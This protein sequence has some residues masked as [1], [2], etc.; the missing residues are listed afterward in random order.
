MTATPGTYYADGLSIIADYM[1]DDGNRH[2][3]HVADVTNRNASN[4]PPSTEEL[5]TARLLA[6]APELLAMLETATKALIGD[7]D[8]WYENITTPDGDIPDPYDAHV[9][10]QYD[11]E[12]EAFLAI[13][14]KSKG[15]TA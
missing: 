9:L 2:H 5:D 12:I 6:A 3:V 1:D 8:S 11:R 14:A 15:P 7:R 4:R 13:I 10:A